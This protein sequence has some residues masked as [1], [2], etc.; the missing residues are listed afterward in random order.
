M[1]R[2][3]L[4]CPLL[5]CSLVTGCGDNVRVLIG[6]NVMPT[7]ATAL[8][9]GGTVQFTATG[10]FSGPSGSTTIIVV[11]SSSDTSIAGVNN[12]GLAT[13]VQSGGPVTISATAPNP[14]ATSTTMVSGGINVSGTALLTCM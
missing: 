9:P 5:V 14:P 2:L 6:I 12:G 1:R 7:T 8:A 3:A 11:W 4:L 13:C 10:V